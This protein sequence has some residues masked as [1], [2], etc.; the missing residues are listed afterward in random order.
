MKNYKKFINEGM[1]DDSLL[2]LK[3][4]IDSMFHSKSYIPVVGRIE[5]E[6]PGVNHF[7][8]IASKW[9]ETVEE[10]K[11]KELHDLLIKLSKNRHLEDFSDNDLREIYFFLKRHNL[12]SSD[13]IEREFINASSNPRRYG[14][15][16]ERRED[17]KGNWEGEERR[18][19][20]KK[21][22][23]YRHFTYPD[24]DTK[25]MVVVNKKWE[26]CKKLIRKLHNYGKEIGILMGVIAFL[27]TTVKPD[28]PLGQKLS[29][30]S[31]LIKRYTSASSVSDIRK[32]QKSIDEA[33]S[34]VDDELDKE[35]KKMR[36]EKTDK[37]KE[38]EIKDW[39]EEKRKNAFGTEDG[40][41]HPYGNDEPGA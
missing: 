18:S 2:Y 13:S 27:I 22:I 40:K 34:D 26:F 31:E 6:Y 17:G 23:G 35:Y 16:V 36:K 33:E 37:R 12:Y 4:K 28:S 20:K 19:E 3:K 25:K 15:K 9:A 10:D 32:L 38:D 8:H 24:L 5:Q 29:K 21:L 39:K 30:L 7:L 1:W 41:N 11:N 14:D